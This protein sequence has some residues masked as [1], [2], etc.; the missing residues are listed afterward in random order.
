MG[1][2]SS[3]LSIFKSD[4]E[5]SDN[6]GDKQLRTHYYKSGYG[7]VFQAVLDLYSSAEYKIMA[8]S[9]E[10]GEITVQKSGFPGYFIVITV[11]NV[12]AIETAVDFKISTEKK[13]PGAY[14]KLKQEIASSYKVL[15]SSLIRV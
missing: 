12:Q 10:R 13:V 6:Q 9:R 15:D 8:E 4:L 1:V 7:R 11:I 2:F 14:P 3:I 5:T